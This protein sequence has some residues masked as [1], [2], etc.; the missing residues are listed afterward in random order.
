MITIEFHEKNKTLFKMLLEAAIQKFK[1]KSSSRNSK[2]PRKNN[3]VYQKLV[4][5]AYVLIQ[6]HESQEQDN[7][8]GQTQACSLLFTFKYESVQALYFRPSRAAS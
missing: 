2:A 3:C 8:N 5:Q 1:K 4:L 6:F 7:R